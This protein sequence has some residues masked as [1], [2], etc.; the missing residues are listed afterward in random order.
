MRRDRFQ[1]PREIESRFDS[2]CAETGAPIPRGTWALYYAGS[3]GKVYHAD[4]SMA[5][6]WRLDREDAEH[7]GLEYLRILNPPT[8]RS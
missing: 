7:V 6:Q 5:R 3:P 8:W 4:S 1:G 2:V